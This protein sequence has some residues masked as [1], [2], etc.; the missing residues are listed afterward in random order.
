[1]TKIEF[2]NNQV[3]L[4]SDFLQNYMRKN[5]I[6]SLTADDSAELLANN[7]ILSNE[8]GPKQGFNFRQMLRDGRDG[9]IDFVK[10]TEQY[11]NGRWIIYRVL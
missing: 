8:I 11:K 7:G 9:K 4:V 2:N 5:D 10:G 6:I 1:M 3:K